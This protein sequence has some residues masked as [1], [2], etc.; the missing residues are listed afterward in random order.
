MAEITGWFT[1][2]G[3]HI[4]IMKGQSKTEAA[5]K[6]MN[7]KHGKTVAK[8]SSKTKGKSGSKNISKEDMDNA[9]FE[10]TTSRYQTINKNLR[11]EKS[12]T[13][14]DTKLVNDLDSAIDNSSIPSGTV[15]YRGTSP[16]ALGIKTNINKMTSADVKSLVG[17]TFT[18]KAYMSTSKSKAAASNFSGRGDYSGKVN[19]IITTKGNKKGLDVGSNS[20]FGKKE[21]EVILPR[22]T[23][24]KIT[25]AS[26]T[27][28][29]LTVH[30]EY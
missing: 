22:N 28:N 27:A 23:K 13:K 16:E 11:N 15:L 3:M 20:N 6:Y 8:L 21:K 14:K 29:I 19:F 25:K 30:L 1:M 5:S 18:D 9:V 10:Y 12:L 26:R 24:L 4:P 2:N 7:S 17:T